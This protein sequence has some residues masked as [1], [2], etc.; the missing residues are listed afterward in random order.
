MPVRIFAKL[1][2][3]FNYDALYTVELQ[4]LEYLWD[5]VNLFQV[6]VVRATEG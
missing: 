5:P 4:W 1:E 2:M 3:A 6:W